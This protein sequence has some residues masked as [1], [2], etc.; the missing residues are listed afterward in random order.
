MAGLPS[1]PGT[2]RTLAD[3]PGWSRPRRSV[4]AKDASS[5][6]RKRDRVAVCRRVGPV[7]EEAYLHHGQVLLVMSPL[8]GLVVIYSSAD[9]VG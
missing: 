1:W 9:I 6:P 8:L 2:R 5:G 7:L 3:R 4:S